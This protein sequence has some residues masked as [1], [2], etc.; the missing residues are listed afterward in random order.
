MR[1]IWCSRLVAAVA[2]IAAC[3]HPRRC[4]VVGLHGGWAAERGR[5]SRRVRRGAV[6]VE[7]RRVLPWIYVEGTRLDKK[8][9][10]GIFAGR[11][12]TQLEDNLGSEQC[13]GDLVGTNAGA[14]NPFAPTS[15]VS[16]ARTA[17]PRSH[18]PSR[19]HSMRSSSSVS[20]LRRSTPRGAEWRGSW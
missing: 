1:G 10:R 13:F 18:M 12:L 5:S 4:H 3:R 19:D 2:V 6:S 16:I 11:P 17:R 20:L 7:R 8:F 14:H 15:S 9:D